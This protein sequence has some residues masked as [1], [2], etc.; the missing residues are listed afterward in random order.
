MAKGGRVDGG[1]EQ[2]ERPEIVS[3]AMDE[4]VALYKIQKDAGEAFSDAVKAVAVK[5]GF[6]AKTVRSFAVAKAGEKYSERKRES[7]QLSLLFD[8]VA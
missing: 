7:V 2:I 4:L 6:L 8:E 1:Q 5:S 3:V